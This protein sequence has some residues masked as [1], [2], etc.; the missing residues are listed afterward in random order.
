MAITTY[1]E[2]QS[3]VLDWIAR[4]ELTA[5]APDFIR[6]AELEFAPLLRAKVVRAALTISAE[7]TTLPADVAELR[8]VRLNTDSYKHVLQMV[9]PETLAD[10]RRSSTGVPLW[11]CV[12]DGELIV[13]PAPSDSFDAEIIYFE[14]LTPLSDANPTNSTLTAAPNIYLF[15]ALAQAETY[16]EHDARVELWTSKAASAIQALNNQ[17]EQAELGAAPRQMRLPTVIG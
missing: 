12:I 17:R 2:L 4:P 10:Y 5:L 9:T 15:S 3:A 14:A 16:L 1:T 8:S 11:G 6:L 13:A 7:A